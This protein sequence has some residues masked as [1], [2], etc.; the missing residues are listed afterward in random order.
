MSMSK[1]TMFRQMTK[2]Q[3]VK[4]CLNVT[5]SYNMLRE[6]YDYAVSQLR[7]VQAQLRE[8]SVSN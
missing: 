4:Q 3:L 5:T 8:L 2:E 6:E 7:A 1:E